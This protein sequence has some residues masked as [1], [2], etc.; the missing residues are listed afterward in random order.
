MILL[1]TCASKIGLPMGHE[2]WNIISVCALLQKQYSPKQSLYLTI[3]LQIYLANMKYG[4][5]QEDHPSV[6]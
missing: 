5:G 6:R 3:S 2:S 1:T 4:Q